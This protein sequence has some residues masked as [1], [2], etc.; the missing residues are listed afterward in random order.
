MVATGGTLVY[1]RKLLEKEKHINTGGSIK[2]S[3]I[4]SVS[5]NMSAS[6]LEEENQPLSGDTT[7]SSRYFSVW[8]SYRYRNHEIFG[9][10]PNNSLIP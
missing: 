7:G 2:L 5:T 9:C 8:T 3:D 6:I 1:L 10:R 4:E